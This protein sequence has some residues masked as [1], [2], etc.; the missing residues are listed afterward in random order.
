MG[1]HEPGPGGAESARCGAVSGLGVKLV[2]VH[3]EHG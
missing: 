3:C 2:V 1:A